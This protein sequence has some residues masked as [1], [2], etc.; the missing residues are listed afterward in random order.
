MT[1]SCNSEQN[2]HGQRFIRQLADDI[3]NRRDGGAFTIYKQL[4]AKFGNVTFA[5]F[6]EAIYLAKAWRLFN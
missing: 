2:S 4:E 3:A 6:V 5:E 1:V